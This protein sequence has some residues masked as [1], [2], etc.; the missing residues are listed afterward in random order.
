MLPSTTTHLSLQN[1]K[2]CSIMATTF[3]SSDIRKAIKA[4]VESFLAAYEDGA[5]QNDASIINVTAA[6]TRH[7]LPSSVP[8]VL[9]LPADFSIN[10]ATFQ[11]VF[12]KDINFLKF[13]NSFMSNLV[14]D[15]E[16]RRAAF[17]GV[18]K[19]FVV[20]SGESYPFECSFALYLTEDGS[21][22][23]KVVEFLD[24]DGTMNM[25]TASTEA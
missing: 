12:A 14:I 10:N 3:S 5:A 11:E 24:K 15:T 9:G 21:K 23:R 2:A 6:C 13:R 22:A 20:N 19:V 17:T 1:S 4:T 25:A 8:K 7:L 16:E 18:S